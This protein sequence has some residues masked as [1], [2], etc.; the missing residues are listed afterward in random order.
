MFI[1]K[2][3]FICGLNDTWKI[4]NLFH[5]CHF[6][7][8]PTVKNHDKKWAFHINRQENMSVVVKH[9]DGKRKS[10]SCDSFFTE[11]QTSGGLERPSQL[12]KYFISYLD[13]YFHVAAT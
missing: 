10:Q 12:P 1:A 4:Y 5:C 2:H 7:I 13:I 8:D 3:Y 11:S 6:N 9:P